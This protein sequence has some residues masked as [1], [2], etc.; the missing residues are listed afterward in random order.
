[1][2][3]LTVVFIRDVNGRVHRTV[4]SKRCRVHADIVGCLY[5][6]AQFFCPCLLIEDLFD[7]IVDKF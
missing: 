6:R 3:P 1:M 5:E 4:L 2:P 7:Q